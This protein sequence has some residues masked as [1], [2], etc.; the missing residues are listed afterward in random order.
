MWCLPLLVLVLANSSCGPGDFD[1]ACVLQESRRFEP[2]GGHPLFRI[3]GGLS[4]V[5]SGIL[6]VLRQEANKRTIEQIRAR[7]SPA[8]ALARRVRRNQ[9]YRRI[10]KQK[11]PENAPDVSPDICT[12]NDV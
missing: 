4:K 12:H 1:V 11:T 10:S 5:E 9:I 6:Y 3:R 2:D 8:A 7:H